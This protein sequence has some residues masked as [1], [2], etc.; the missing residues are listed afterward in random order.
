MLACAA[1]A[2]DSGSTDGMTSGGAADRHAL[3]AARE[4]SLPAV[5][6]S[7]E[8]ETETATSPVPGYVASRSATGTKTDTP[9]IETPQSISVITADQIQAQGA[10]TVGQALRYT[11]GV[12][13]EQYGGL[14]TTVDYYMVRGFPNQ[15][16]FVDGLSTETYF[17]LLA[18]AVDPYALERIDVLRGPSSVLYGQNIPGGMINLVTKRPTEEPLHEVSMDVGNYGTVGARF[19]LGGPLT[20]DGTVLYR[21]TGE[22]GTAGSQVDYQTDKRFF[23][24]P[25]LTW[26]PSADTTLTLL[27]QFSYRNSSDPTV[28]LPAVGTLYPGPNGARIR[29]SLFDGEP[30]FNQTRRSEEDIGYEFEHRFNDWLTVRQNLRYTHVNLDKDVVGDAG[31]EDDQVTMDRYA[32]DAK[33]SADIFTVDNQAQFKFATG[34][35]QHT[36]LVGVDYV[37]SIDRWAE[38]DATDVPSLNLYAPVYGA[39]ISFGGVDYSVEHHLDQVGVYA[40]DQV[41]LG[42]LVATFGVRQDWADTDEFDRIA[43][44]TDQ[45]NSEQRFT[46]RAGLVYLFDSGFAPYVS[47]AT[48]FQPG[49]GTTFDGSAL[50]PTTGQ[51]VEVGVKYQPH[52]QKSFA[53]LSLFNI[54]QRNVTEP[55]YS[56]PDGNYVV[57][58]GAQRVKGIELSGVADLGAGMNL[59]AAYTYMD[60]TISASDQ[61]YAGNAAPNVP[62]N[63]ASLWFDKTF[64]QGWYRGFGVGAGVRY[65]GAQYGDEANDVKMPSVTLF[66]AAIHYDIAHWRFSVNAQNLFDRV[67][68]NC[69]S[70]NYCAY[71]LRRSVI[72]RATYQW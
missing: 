54:L 22:A 62:H 7:G 47:Y 50:K 67:Y 53:M 64:Q 32:F 66:D 6:V 38:N 27:S 55:D 34:A 42:K 31:L 72:G 14:D 61:G 20:K 16:P 24:A 18:P 57:Q 25:A 69:Q 15:F 36:A 49:L 5:K 37:H 30:N 68:V 21:L 44:A 46:Y 11:P 17:T 33:A 43:G 29:T 23:I 10:Q 41:R 1:H 45:S 4:P 65:L 12:I 40:Q 71:G 60:G 52:G 9:I 58:T 2:Q 8:R 63:M 35:L 70:T 51:S 13:G 19:D 28:D 26:K 3:A 48:S 39:P 59:T 56:H